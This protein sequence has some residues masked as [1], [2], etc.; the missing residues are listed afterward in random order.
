VL[1][2]VMDHM[3]ALAKGFKIFGPIIGGIM[4]KVSGRQHHLRYSNDG[5][6]PNESKARQRTSTPIAPRPVFLVPPP[7]V[8]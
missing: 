6:V 4:I 8:T 5:A 2:A 3:A 7:A 1:I